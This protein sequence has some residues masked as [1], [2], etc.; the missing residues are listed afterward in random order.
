[1]EALQPGRA[2]VVFKGDEL[3][4][5]EGNT[6]IQKEDQGGFNELK[7]ASHGFLEPCRGGD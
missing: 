1:M 2:T 3:I 4:S 5:W 6:E 7:F